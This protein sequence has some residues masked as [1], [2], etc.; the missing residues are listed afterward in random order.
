MIKKICNYSAII[1]LSLVILAGAVSANPHKY[2]PVKVEGKSFSFYNKF[3]TVKNPQ[4][5]SLTV[6]EGQQTNVR[7]QSNEGV[8]V[9][10]Y[11][12]GGEIKEY[13]DEKYF[14]LEFN[15]AGEYVIELN[16]ASLSK[17]ILKA[18]TK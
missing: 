15:A 16:S 1:L 18:S 11:L 2:G 14:N 12:P 5:Y 10:L 8:S 3:L 4:S 9:K 17:Y 7:I 6:K 13:R